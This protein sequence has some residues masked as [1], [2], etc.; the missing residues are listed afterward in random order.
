M[1]QD[2]PFSITFGLHYSAKFILLIQS[3]QKMLNLVAQETRKKCITC[4]DVC[5][6][7]AYDFQMQFVYNYFEVCPSSF[8]VYLR[9]TDMKSVG[10]YF[11]KYIFYGN[12]CVV[13]YLSNVIMN[14]RFK[15]YLYK[16]IIIQWSFTTT[17]HSEHI[18]WN[19]STFHIDTTFPMF[20]RVICRCF[21]NIYV[22]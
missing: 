18:V 5:L 14:F 12:C 8:N 10:V 11:S 17:H 2:T 22:F 7:R 19:L 6:T 1:K 20:R 9:H 15:E 13:T 4:L 21:K 3:K 16:I